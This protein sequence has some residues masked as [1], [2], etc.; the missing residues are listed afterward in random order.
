MYSVQKYIAL[1]KRGIFYFFFSKEFE[2]FKKA[3]SLQSEIRSF[4][5]NYDEKNLS[6]VTKK[7]KK[8]TWFPQPY[9]NQKRSPFIG[10]KKKKRQKETYGFRRT[11]TQKIGTNQ[12]Y[13]TLTSTSGFFFAL[14][15]FLEDSEVIS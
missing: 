6:T 3:L 5:V 7:K 8:Q 12:L 15:F 13:Q 1:L 11:S 2:I 10:S 9:G 14:N 4:K